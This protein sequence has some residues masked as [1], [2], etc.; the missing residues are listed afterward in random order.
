MRKERL[1]EQKRQ[2]IIG[3][4]TQI[5]TVNNIM[6]CLIL[7]ILVW[8]MV[9]VGVSLYSFDDNNSDEPI[10]SALTGSIN[11]KSSECDSNIYRMPEFI[12]LETICSNMKQFKLKGVCTPQ[13]CSKCLPPNAVDKR[14]EWGNKDAK[15]W[16]DTYYETINSRRVV[17]KEML[18][19]DINEN[20]NIL[21]MVINYGYS[22]LF[23]N[24]YC[25]MLNNLNKND[26]QYYHSNA[27]IVVTEEK[28]KKLLTEKTKFKHIYYPE[29]LGKNL[30][31]ITPDM[32]DRFALGSHR[33]CVA[34]QIA[35]INDL[36]HLGYNV[37]LQDSD[38]I[39]NGNPMEY[40]I[41]CYIIMKYINYYD[42]NI[43][44]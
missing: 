9:I 35:T 41:V 18:N 6:I 34:L 14:I 40:L 28:T 2:Q 32:P 7:T 25:S 30:K 8:A 38:I 4:K 26:I 29:W 16:I 19:K 36:V 43:E 12:E 31:R 3:A 11:I 15:P 13:N 42:I 44:R 20:R 5:C 23:L 33:W 24:W 27:L 10:S 1:F 21:L 39:W 22:Y 17:L 37:L